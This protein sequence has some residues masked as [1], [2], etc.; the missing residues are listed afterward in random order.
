VWL[1]LCCVIPQQWT[2]T[3]LKTNCNYYMTF[4]KLKHTNIIQNHQYHCLNPRRR[5]ADIFN[6]SE[7]CQ[8]RC[9]YYLLKHVGQAGGAFNTWFKE[10]K[11]EQKKNQTPSTLNIQVAQTLANLK[12]SCVLMGMFRFKSARQCGVVCTGQKRYFHKFNK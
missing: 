6:K 2:S 7:I 4:W 12:H 11:E 1:N 3:S 10:H 8:L 9:T 5:T